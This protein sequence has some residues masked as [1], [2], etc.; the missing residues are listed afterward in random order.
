MLNENFLLNFCVNEVYI[1]F[2]IPN[3]MLQEVVVSTHLFNIQVYA[4]CNES[5]ASLEGMCCNSSS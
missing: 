2:K 1:K 5:D 3:A 4:K